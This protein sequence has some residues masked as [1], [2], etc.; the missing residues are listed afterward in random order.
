VVA[1]AVP[2]HGKPYSI[3]VTLPPLSTVAFKRAN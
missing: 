2:F 3:S 1:D